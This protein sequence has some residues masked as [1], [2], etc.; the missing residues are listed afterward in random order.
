MFVQV[1][2]R[3]ARRCSRRGRKLRRDCLR[4]EGARRQA[5]S[6]A[7]GEQGQKTSGGEVLT[8]ALLLCVSPGCCNKKQ[9]LTVRSVN[10]FEIAA[11]ISQQVILHVFPCIKDVN[12]FLIIVKLFL[13]Q[14]S[15]IQS[16]FRAIPSNFLTS[17]RTFS[18]C[19]LHQYSGQPDK[20]FTSF[21]SSEFLPLSR[22]STATKSCHDEA[23][24]SQP[25][26][27]LFVWLMSLQ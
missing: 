11:F 19:V 6:Q 24:L 3:W 16:S 8:H 17:A 18:K 25:R 13:Y 12:I 15:L 20:I 2:K 23:E 21:P 4:W 5:G 7:R 14:L 26:F 10:K 9:S 27:Y 22:K 1:E